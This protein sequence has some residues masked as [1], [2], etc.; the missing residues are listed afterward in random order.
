MPG[1]RRVELAHWDVPQDQQFQKT[2]LHPLREK[3]A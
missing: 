1:N 2:L 3:I